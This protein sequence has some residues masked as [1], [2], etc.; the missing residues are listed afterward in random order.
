MRVLQINS[1]YDQGGAARIVACIHRQLALDGREAYVAFGRGRKSADADTYR[2]GK[3]LEICFSALMS[4]VTGVTGRF[5]RAATKRLIAHIR[6]IRPDI[7][8]L[9]ALHGYYLNLPMLFD[10]INAN[11]IPCVWTFHDCY[12]FT[13]NCGYFFCCDRWKTGCGKCPDIR[14]YPKSMWFD[15]TRYLWEK[16]K[17]LFT[18]GGPRIIVTPSH[19]LTQHA[20]N[21]FFGKYE[22]VTVRNGIDT[23]NTFYPRGKEKCREKYGFD[24]K[25]KLILGIAADYRDK[26]KGAA[27]ILQ[28]AKDLSGEAKIILIG[29]DKRNDELLQ[30]INNV[31][32]LPATS[33]T[34]VL[35]EYYTLADV[36][37]LPSLAENYATVTLESMACGTPVVGFAAGGTPEQLSGG[38][39]IAVQPGDQ[40]EFDAAVRN[41]LADGEGQDGL[42]ESGILWGDRLA[43]CIRQEN[44][45]RKM[46]E[47]YEAIYER[48]L[49][50]PGSTL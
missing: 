5:N 12:A 24:R 42:G 26:R 22:C 25:E 20:K 13:G 2:F 38:K 15:R 43:E 47:E 19:W 40:Q 44:S 23:E 29:W 35:A 6:Q 14:I 33:D 3:P 18:A 34:D 4:R 7:I 16:K 46:T 49:T 8:H 10:Y 36:F 48:L 9:H 41:L 39:G 28:L 32:T 31:I 37:V 45:L 50:Y 27:Y 1:H 17:E 21:S 30:G 11:Q